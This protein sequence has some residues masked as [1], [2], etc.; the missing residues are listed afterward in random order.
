MKIFIQQFHRAAIDARAN[1]CCTKFSSAE[2]FARVAL[3]FKKKE[4]KEKRRLLGTSLG[5]KQRKKRVENICE[6]NIENLISLCDLFV[7]S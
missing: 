6:M 5:F 7:D 1:I 4:K 2:M 3:S